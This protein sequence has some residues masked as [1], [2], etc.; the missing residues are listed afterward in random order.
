MLYAVALDP[1]HPATRT[2]IDRF[3]AFCAMGVTSAPV[4]GQLHQPS[5]RRR[6]WVAPDMP[7]SFPPVDGERRL[8]EDR[9]E[10]S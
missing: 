10:S 3:V 6:G 7:C 8:G 5:A 9:E 4:C 2:P 1:F